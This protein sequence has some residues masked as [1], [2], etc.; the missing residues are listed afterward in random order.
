MIPDRVPRWDIGPVRRNIPLILVLFCTVLD[1]IVRHQYFRS[2]MVTDLWV[3]ILSVA[4]EISAWLIVIRIA[5]KRRAAGYVFLF[6]YV[7][8]FLATYTFYAYFKALPGINTFSYMFLVPEDFFGIAG[9]GFNP[10]Y[11]LVAIGF[12]AGLW[13][14]AKKMISADAK[15]S[16][17][18]VVAAVVLCLLS[19]A[20]L[21]R[22]ISHKDNR[23][24][25]FTNSIFSIVNG[26]LDFRD[27]KQSSYNLMHRMIRLR[28]PE[29]TQKPEFNIVLVINESLNASCF[30]E[31]GS[32]LD[33]TPRLSSF[34]EKNRDDIF[35]FPRAFSNS[36]VTK[37]SVSNLLAGRNPIEGMSALGKSPLLYEV[38]RNNL[39]PY[40]T[41]LI[42]SWSYT[43][44]NFIDFV[45][46]P[47]LD[48]SRYQEHTRAEKV[49]NVCSDDSL[50]TPQFD[51]FL[52]TVGGGGR[53]CAILHYG[54]THYPYFSKPGDRVFPSSDRF[55]SDYLAS[56]R[57]LDRNISSV[58]SLIDS[59][60]LM[61]NTVV[62]FTSDH[63]EAFGEADRRWGHLGMFT[64]YTTHVPFWVYVPE[65]MLAA[66]PEIRAAFEKNIQKN[67]TNNDIFP[68]VL[69]LYGL[70]T[71]SGLKFG[72]SLLTDVDPRRE[73]Y[74][75]NGL[76]EN[77]TDNHEYIGIIRE[78]DFFSVETDV[79]CSRFCLY[80]LA[81]GRQSGNLWGR[82][83]AKDAAFLASLRTNNMNMFLLRPLDPERTLFALL[84][85]NRIGEFLR[86]KQFIGH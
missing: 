37:V 49:C 84:D 56:L 40:R 70:K 6:L 67:I 59:R 58:L 33:T 66:R 15:P 82:S 44:A 50:I 27:G 5:A 74:V 52:D 85:N 72:R 62:I 81:D 41:A 64:T 4:F 71:E 25:P 61:S 18:V 8:A 35:L 11:L 51:E 31:Y 24:L 39:S 53:F 19:G 28:K 34:I 17:R 60:G 55:L 47:Y 80:Q 23:A 69:D 2:A 65:Q 68:T 29:I 32:K 43:P 21:N 3:Y 78:N 45:S 63:A 75:F 26:Y 57:N 36:T 30:R 1:M 83:P 77:R 7:F 13:F 9:D 46:S 38:L 14:A 48:F 16:N 76:K 54:N 79:D 42:T 20:V 73:I 22:A 10:W 86:S 12:F